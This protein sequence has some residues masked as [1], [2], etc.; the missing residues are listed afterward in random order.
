MD[1]HTI[2][3]A[4]API[5]CIDTCSILDVM[6]DP[7]R[8]TAKPHDR[9]AAIDLVI[10]AEAGNLVLLMAEQ[11]EIEFAEHDQAVQDEAERNLKKLVE[12]VKRLDKLS[13]V[14]GAQGAVSLRHL[15]DHVPRAR[16]IVERWLA[17]LQKVRT[18]HLAPGKAFARVNAGLAPAKRGKESSKDC[19]IYETYLEVVG[20]LRDA[21][22]RA[23]IVFLSS[24]I[25]EYLTGVL[26]PEI[27]D[28]FG[29]LNV[30]YASNMSAAKHA[31]GI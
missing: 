1:L 3:S 27:A 30:V 24:N 20:A 22:V 31:L 14:Y 6:R 12:Q 16:K 8:E 26:R 15:S 25:H 19:L 18:S 13:T 28:D 7:T 11:V 9:Q 17:Q 10:A 29:K 23:K 4:A 5:L 21:G 2:E